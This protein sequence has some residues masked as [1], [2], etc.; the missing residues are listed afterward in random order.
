MRRVLI[1]LAFSTLALTF[2]LGCTS[3]EGIAN[4]LTAAGETLEPD[5]HKKRPPREPGWNEVSRLKSTATIAQLNRVADDASLAR[6]TRAEAIFS[7]FANNVK[8]PGGAV[9]MSEIFR[10][11]NWLSDTNLE[12]VYIV[13]GW[14]PIDWTF[15]DTAFCLR[16]FPDKEGLSQWTIYFS[17]SGSCR[18]AEEARAF[19]RRAQDLKGNPRLKEFALCFPPEKESEL[20]GRIERFSE[21]GIA[22]YQP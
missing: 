18:T 20:L 5:G 2:S 7:L 19:L 16:L 8:P 13:T 14:V 9:A 21:M 11:N 1:Q 17:L 15:S 10:C 3:T 4:Y 6:E 22:V 12:G